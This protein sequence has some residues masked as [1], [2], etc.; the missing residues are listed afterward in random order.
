MKQILLIL[1]V[2]VGYG[3]TAQVSF[4][5]EAPLGTGNTGSSDIKVDVEI[6]NELSTTQTTFWSIDR[7]GSSEP[8]PEEWRFQVCDKN[9]CYVWGLEQCPS[10]QPAVFNANESFTY[11]L[12]MDPEGIAGE[13]SFSF[14]IT[15][16]DGTILTSI[17]VEYKIDL[18][19]SVTEADLDV[20]QLQFY[21]NPTSDFIQITN[22]SKVSK[23]AIYNIVGKRLHTSV[24]YT[25]KSHDV[26]GLQKGIYLVRLFDEG[27]NVISVIRLNKN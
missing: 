25:G 1:F 6:T 27:D 18:V 19:S 16:E 8:V 9:S 23:L 21:P 2:L 10:S 11:N 13:G 22:D 7:M 14:N 15:A 5:P 20:K 26:S 24:H 4:A 17:P 12:H 3:L